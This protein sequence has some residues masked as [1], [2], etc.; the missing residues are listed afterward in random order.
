[1]SLLRLPID[2][3]NVLRAGILKQERLIVRR[4]CERAPITPS[5]GEIREV[6]HLLDLVVPDPDA[7]DCIFSPVIEGINILSVVRNRNLPKT[8]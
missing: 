8:R 3:V 2:R 4:E 6:G 7:H 1:M 5:E